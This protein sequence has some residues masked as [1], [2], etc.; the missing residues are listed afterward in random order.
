MTIQAN[1]DNNRAGDRAGRGPNSYDSKPGRSKGPWI[2]LVIL[3]V[4]GTAGF[5]FWRYQ[6]VRET[7]DDAQVDGHINP[8]AARVGGPV[9]RVHV[10]DNQSVAAGTLLL[11]I[12]P[13]DYQVALERAQAELAV[14]EA[15]ARAA[16]AA[17]PVT[18]IAT[19]SQ[20]S[21]AQ[22]LVQS[23]EARVTVAAREV[24]SARARLGPL[25]ARLRESE[26]LFTRST[27]DL[28]RMKQL[29]AKDE[30]SRQQ[31]DAA[32]TSAEALRA[33]RDAAIA[34]LAE[35]EKGVAAAEA[36]LVQVRAGVL[37][38]QAAMHAA[39]SGPSQVAITRSNVSAAEARVLQARAALD[40]A[41]LNL[42]YTKVHSPVAGIVSM[43]KV[44]IGQVVQRE[45]P[46]MALVQLD[47][48]W[49][50]ANFKEDQL[51]HMR[52]DQLVI[53]TVDAY[54]GRQYRGRVE[55]IAA[56]TGARFSLL[57]PEN[58]AGNYIKVV[59]RIPV[60]IVLEKG[61]DP[62]HL[63]RQGMSVVP[64]VFTR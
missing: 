46:L 43:K 14:T 8:I 12:D 61:Q 64:T 27:Q 63:L 11:E 23:A 62:E 52:V 53:L 13:R 39:S 40:Q 47:D 22:A 15:A 29:I 44:E 34:A 28:E 37:E 30:I 18:A 45:Q 38:A 57:P 10:Q 36:R 21:G 42:E 1:P 41:Q 60:K 5:W 55:S 6:A 20:L 59:Q 19:S 48:I 2:L 9:I 17:V 16:G 33:S 25:Q 31:F 56:A 7:T 4:G 32:V 49:V 51:Q 26:A 54:G 24:D 58:A 50:T 35:T 3:I